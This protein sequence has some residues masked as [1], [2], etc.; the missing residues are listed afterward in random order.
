MP[1]LLPPS[2]PLSKIG[3]AAHDLGAA[4]LFGGNLLARA[5]LHP[6]V[7]A[8]SDPAERGKVVNATWQR[9]GALNTASL[10]A[11]VGGWAGARLHESAPRRL[12]PV[13]RR[14]ALAKDVLVA[15]VAVTGIASG[16]QGQAFARTAREGAVPLTDGDHTAPEA[17]D[18]S[19]RAKR[20]INR[21]GTASLL[22]DA[23]L[24]AV[25]AALAQEGFRRPPARR[26]V[27]RLGRV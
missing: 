18:A 6:S 5:G 1:E 21:I 10:L 13:E 26:L 20:R 15:A 14:L 17:S 22:A 8:I 24:I 19:R 23:G 2:V 12:S 11:V 27:P 9:Y 16:I 3:R 25:N 4:G 7:T